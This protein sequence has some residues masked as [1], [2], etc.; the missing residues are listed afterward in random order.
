MMEE[1]MKETITLWLTN[2][3]IMYFHL[4]AIFDTTMLSITRKG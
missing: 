3:Q 1:E 4:S 2:D